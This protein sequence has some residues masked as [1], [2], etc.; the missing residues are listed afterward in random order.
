LAKHQNIF[1]GPLAMNYGQKYGG[2]TNDEQFAI[3]A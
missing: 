3:A 1:I 2:A